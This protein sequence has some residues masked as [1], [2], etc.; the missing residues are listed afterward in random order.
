MNPQQHQTESKTSKYDDREILK[1]SQTVRQ[2]ID[3]DTLHNN[4]KI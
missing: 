3:I 2:R 1:K 4:V